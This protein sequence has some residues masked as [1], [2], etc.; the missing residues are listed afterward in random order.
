M[1]SEAKNDS[2]LALGWKVNND[3]E[4]GIKKII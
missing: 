1:F 2:I 4:K 3:L